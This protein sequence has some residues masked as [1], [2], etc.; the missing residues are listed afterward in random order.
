MDVETLTS[1]VLSMPDAKRS[2]R[3]NVPDF[4]VAG[5]IFASLPS[6]QFLVLK[7]T[8]EQQE[9]TIRS[10]PEIFSPV[11]GTFGG[12]GWTNARISALN[13]AAALSA[14]TLAW[15]NVSP[16]SDIH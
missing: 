3:Q 11:D 5:K 7:L 6:S 8:P 15:C 14:I 2:S 4:R 13:E 9:T 16:D 1:L 12:Q 10:D